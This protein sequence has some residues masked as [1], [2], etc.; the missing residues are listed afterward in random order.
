M[1]KKL[2]AYRDGIYTIRELLAFSQVKEDTLRSRLNQG[3]SVEEAVEAPPC[4]F[5]QRERDALV[6]NDAN[7]RIV[8]ESPL[9]V[10]EE[11]Q[12]VLHRLYSVDSF[13]STRKT[14]I[15]DFCIITL[16]NGRK[17]ITYPNEFRVVFSA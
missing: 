8:F 9:P 1:K 10:K 11:F 6:R 16:E 2:Y 3:W 7:V 4:P 5:G 15:K 17:L 13:H 14:K 12:P